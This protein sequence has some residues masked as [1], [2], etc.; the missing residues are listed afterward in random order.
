MS[1]L[2]KPKRMNPEGSDTCSVEF[3]CGYNT[4]DDDLT[5]YYTQEIAKKDADIERLKEDNKRLL[6]LSNICEIDKNETLEENQRLKKDI[7]ILQQDGSVNLGVYHDNERLA[8]ENKRLKKG[9]FI[10]S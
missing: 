7:E 10:L 6:E 8:K 9:A 3:A 5:M 2:K 4:A 1:E